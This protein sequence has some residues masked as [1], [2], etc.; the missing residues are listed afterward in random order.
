MV[1]GREDCLSEDNQPSQT[2]RILLCRQKNGSAEGTYICASL[3]YSTL[4]SGLP[5]RRRN[6]H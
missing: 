4:Q 1:S 5:S 6:A 2:A 3:K